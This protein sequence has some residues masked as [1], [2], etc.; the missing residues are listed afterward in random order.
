VA[1]LPAESDSAKVRSGAAGES[2]QHLGSEGIAAL[3]AVWWEL[4]L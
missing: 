2:R 1:G 4:I 3:D